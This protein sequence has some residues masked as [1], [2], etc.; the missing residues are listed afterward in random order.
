MVGFD[1]I[2]R[3][4]RRVVE[5]GGHELVN[6]RQQAPG[7][8]CHDLDRLAMLAERRREEPSGCA[9]IAKCRYVDDLAVLIDRPIDVP[10]PAGDL[11][12]GLI[13]VPT[14]PERVATG[15]GCVG[16]ER[17]K[18]LHPPLHGHVVDLDSPLGQELFD[19]AVGEPE[20]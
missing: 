9:G 2:V 7:P 17:G 14:V 3:V 8:V 6:D 1:P 4:P 19:V 13:D 11:H 12:R 15:P 18:S 10:P 16:E 20:P 5:R